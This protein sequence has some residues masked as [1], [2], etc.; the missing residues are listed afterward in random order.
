MDSK[1]A[2]KA[3]MGECGCQSQAGPTLNVTEPQTAQC[4]HSLDGRLESTFTKVLLT[5]NW[6]DTLEER[7]VWQR[8]LIS[9]SRPVWNNEVQS[10]AP[11]LWATM[12][13]AG[14]QCCWKGPGG[15]GWQQVKHVSAEHCCSN[16]KSRP[17]LHPQGHYGQREM[18]LSQLYWVLVRPYL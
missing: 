2:S 13:V 1:L 18:Q 8:D 16:S 5:V 12:H 9:S 4:F 11:R 3:R 10:P 17:G 6:V 14:K 15:T 7:T